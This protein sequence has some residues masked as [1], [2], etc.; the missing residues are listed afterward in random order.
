MDPARVCD[1][2]QCPPE[3]HRRTERGSDAHARHTGCG[4]GDNQCQRAFCIQ[5]RTGWNLQPESGKGRYH[6]DCKAGDHQRR[7]QCDHR[8][9]RWH[10]QFCCRDQG[11]G[12]TSGHCERAGSDF[13][14]YQ[15]LH[16]GGSGNRQQRRCGGD[17]ADSREAGRSPGGGKD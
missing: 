9:A 16:A 12:N 4:G 7:C 13:Y 14:E 10:D 8:P 2:R 17:Q 3:R 1:H 11:Q 5:R 15:H 6:Q